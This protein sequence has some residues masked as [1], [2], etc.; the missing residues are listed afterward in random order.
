MLYKLLIHVVF[1]MF[2]GIYCDFYVS[3][4]VTFVITVI[5]K[6]LLSVNKQY[7]AG[8]VIGCLMGNISVYYTTRAFNDYGR[9]SYIGNDCIFLE[10]KGLYYVES[11]KDLAIADEIQFNYYGNMIKKINR[12]S[13]GS[14]MLPF[15]ANHRQYIKD[16]CMQSNYYGFWL[17]ILLGDKSYMKSEELRSLFDSSTYHLIVISG[18]HL[19]LV[20]YVIY[21]LFMLIIRRSK[22][23][24]Y[25]CTIYAS[26]DIIPHVLASIVCTYY[27]LLTLSGISSLRAIIMILLKKFEYSNKSIL[28]FLMI[29][30]LIYDPMIIF[31]KGFLLSYLITLLLLERQSNLNV[32]LFA[33]T[34]TK[35]INPLSIINNV[36]GSVVIYMLLPIAFIAVIIGQVRLLNLFDSIIEIM[37]KYL[38]SWN[39]KSNFINI[40][41]IEGISLLHYF[42]IHTLNSR[43]LYLS[44]LTFV[45]FMIFS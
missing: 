25:Y 1:G 24:N 26:Y 33:S 31:N 16:F 6:F 32:S 30:S 38:P 43:I 22:K 40:R 13:F 14:L 34:I 8:L 39:I 5:N 23:I 18:F 20:Y 9:I 29:L 3:F 27:F 19:S 15:I 10:N 28:L 4:V 45:I 21:N 17:A 2:V 41:A 35:L 12:K 37:L 7:I 44:F 36:I 11:T 42:Y